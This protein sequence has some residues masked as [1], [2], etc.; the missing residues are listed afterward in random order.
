MVTFAF[1]SFGCSSFSSV[2]GYARC[3]CAFAFTHLRLVDARSRSFCIR[4]TH[5]LPRSRLVRLHLRTRTHTLRTFVAFCTRLRLLLGWLHVYVHVR[6]L[7]TRTH[8]LAVYFVVLV[9]YV[10]LDVYVH[11]YVRYVRRTHA[12]SVAVRFGWL[13]VTRLVPRLVTLVTFA[14]ARLRLLIYVRFGWLRLV[15]YGLVT[16]CCCWLFALLR[17]LPFYVVVA[18]VGYVYV[19]GWFGYVLV[20]WLRLVVAARSHGCPRCRA[21]VGSRLP[22]APCLARI[23][24]VL[25]ALPCL[26]LPGSRVGYL[27][28]AALL[29]PV[30]QFAALRSRLPAVCG[31]YP[32][33]GYADCPVPVPTVYVAQFSYP[34]CPAPR[35]PQFGCPFVRLLPCPGSHVA[36]DLR[37]TCLALP[38]PLRWRLRC[39]VPFPRTLP[40]LPLPC[41]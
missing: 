32:V 11:V 29:T 28:L 9:G 16:R 38:L 40:A 39:P 23:A 34:V 25:R 41:R 36:P 1:S 35:V 37:F 31:C 3:L 12:R 19:V 17:S 6:R 10:R 20:V 5:T 26:A 2:C 14:V 30:A 21:R 18:L 8:A 22:S 13:H 33:P 27:P 15:G 24:R 4:Y 7:R